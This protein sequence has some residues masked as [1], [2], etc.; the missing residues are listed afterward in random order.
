MASLVHALRRRPPYLGRSVPGIEIRTTPTRTPLGESPQ[1]LPQHGPPTVRHIPLLRRP[2]RPIRGYRPSGLPRVLR[3]AAA[4][5][6]LPLGTPSPVMPTPAS[7]TA[8]PM[9]AAVAMM[10]IRAPANRASVSHAIPP[11]RPA[12]TRTPTRTPSTRQTTQSTR[13][14]WRASRPLR[15]RSASSRHTWLHDDAGAASVDARRDPRAA[16]AVP[17]RPGK[18]PAAREDFRSRDSFA[19]DALALGMPRTATTRAE[20]SKAAARATAAVA[21]KARIKAV[22]IR[23]GRTAR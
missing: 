2:P 21:A 20:A 9:A 17:A 22:A 23:L 14:L 12:S 8:P 15:P 19:L 4:I 16:R 18:D 6:R 5:D 11:P 7:S 10:A 1:Q 3:L 13:H